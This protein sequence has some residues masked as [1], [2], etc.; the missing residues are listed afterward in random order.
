MI[1][2]DKKVN[3]WEILFGANIEVLILEMKIVHSKYIK[4]DQD[5]FSFAYFDA[6]LKSNIKNVS[7]K[8]A[9]VKNRKE[10]FE[11]EFF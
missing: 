8:L 5:I 7:L 6:V 9:F 3:V 11:H 1:F 2:Y 4:K 10:S